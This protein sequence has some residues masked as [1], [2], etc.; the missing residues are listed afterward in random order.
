MGLNPTW[1]DEHE[2]PHHAGEGDVEF[3][4]VDMEA[5]AAKQLAPEPADAVKKGKAVVADDAVEKGKVAEPPHLPGAS[6]N[7]A[8]PS[9]AQ[10]ARKEPE[11]NV[12]YQQ[13]YM[14][15]VTYLVHAPH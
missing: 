4:N 14:L 8:G 2:A 13:W 3:M 5:E 1:E 15:P 7:A 6:G 10:A 12:G 11:V 9:N